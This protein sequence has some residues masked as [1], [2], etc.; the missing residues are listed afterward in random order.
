[1]SKKNVPANGPVGGAPV[2]TF[3]VNV[4]AQLEAAKGAPQVATRTDGP[5]AGELDEIK[6]LEELLASKKRLVGLID[7]AGAPKT[8]KIA[9]A[10]PLVRIDLGCGRAHET[11]ASPAPGC[12]L[13]EGWLGAD[14][15]DLKGIAFPKMNLFKFPWPWKDDSVDAL[16][17][18]HFLEHIPM[19]YWNPPRPELGRP[20]ATYTEIPDDPDSQDLL[21]KFMDEA[22]RVLKHDGDFK[23]VVPSATGDRAFQDPT[24]R[25][26]WVQA[27]FFY[28]N[29]EA[30]AG[31]NLGHY[32]TKCHFGFNV[33]NTAPVEESARE[34]EASKLR[35]NHY[36]NTVWDWH[37]QLKAI[38][39]EPKK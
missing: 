17:A 33:G 35:F 15:A 8:V 7:D 12:L 34:P 14:I 9:P 28:F 20:E 30:R 37:A 38:K 19:C 10:E 21:F 4:S 23:I 11:H 32:N 25:R 29:R 39:Q 26:W 6:K 27:T 3:D 18:S 22:W 5:N 1:M 13:C 16:H 31:M 2:P 24:H 36:R